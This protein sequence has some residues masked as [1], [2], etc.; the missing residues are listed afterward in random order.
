MSR[1]LPP[2]R[3]RAALITASFKL[4]EEAPPEKITASALARRAG[5]APGSLARQFGSIEAL[6]STMQRLHYDSTRE[7]M[8]SAIQDQSPGLKRIR[9][10]THAYF[11]YS[12]IHRGLRD[13]L[14]SLRAQSPDLQR[15]WRADN[16][17]Y[18]QF[19]AGE[20]AL[21]GWPNPLV[22]ARLFAA[23]VIELVRHE[24]RVGRKL[25]A[26]RRALER[27]LNMH[28]RVIALP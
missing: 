7:Y 16:Q 1:S 17:F 11:D 24:Q 21:C 26:A 12:F 13:W 22:G 23:A 19:T 3:Q 20:L 9:N 8:L 10:A 27:F 2:Y 5:L 28:E 14:S 18:V 25:P 15:Q 4:V 6:A